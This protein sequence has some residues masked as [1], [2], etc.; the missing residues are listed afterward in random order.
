[1]SATM[2]G[3]LPGSAVWA[4]DGV[5]FILAFL[6]GTWVT[7]WALGALKWD[8]FLFDPFGTQTRVLRFLLALLGGF[9]L[10][11]A[12]VAYILAFQLLRVLV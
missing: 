9:L 6:F 5:L 10:A 11:L 3:T 12:A 4:A 2:M 1:M 7:W 8:K